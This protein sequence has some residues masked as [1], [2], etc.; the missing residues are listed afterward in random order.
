M[1]LAIVRLA[2]GLLLL[3]GRHAR[4]FVS[5]SHPRVRYTYAI[6]TQLENGKADAE[7]DAGI[8]IALLL[9]TTPSAHLLEASQRI[10]SSFQATSGL[11]VPIVTCDDLASDSADASTLMICQQANLLLALGMESPMDV[12]CVATL[13][14]Q[15]RTSDLVENAVPSRP[16]AQFAVGGKPFAPLVDQWDEANP[17]TWQKEIPWSAAAQDRRLMLDMQAMFE[18]GEPDDFVKAIGLF[19]DKKKTKTW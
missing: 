9:P 8:L 4:G 11:E 16:T 1:I 18:K 7:E 14:R 10:A 3:C 13:F 5:V 15:R 19:W 6:T 12:R 17:K 2:F